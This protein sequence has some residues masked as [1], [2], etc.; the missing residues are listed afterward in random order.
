MKIIS[1]G[2]LAIAI[3]RLLT[4]PEA[5]QEVEHFGDFMSRLAQ[6][7]AEHC[8]GVAVGPADDD[9]SDPDGSWEDRWLVGISSASGKEGESLPPW[10]YGLDDDGRW[11]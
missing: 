6:I 5:Y 7:V 3:T 11:P 10:L 9:F 1:N 8:G 2:D 4:D